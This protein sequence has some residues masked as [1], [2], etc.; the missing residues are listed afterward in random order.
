MIT[1]V[2]RLLPDIP[3]LLL[4]TTRE[5]IK[6]N[7]EQVVRFLR[8]MNNSM[9]LIRTEPDRAVEDARKQRYGGDFKAEREALKYYYDS[10]KSDLTPRTWSRYWK[11]PG[12]KRR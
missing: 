8:A 2:G 6:S 5:K 9:N 7:P 1:D 11:S 12:R 4:S 10:F 3:A